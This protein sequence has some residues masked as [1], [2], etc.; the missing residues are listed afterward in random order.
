MLVRSPNGTLL[1]LLALYSIPQT[2][3]VSTSYPKRMYSPPEE[4]VTSQPGP[5]R[6]DWKHILNDVAQDDAAQ[7]DDH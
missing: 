2:V 3:C 7:T 1:F 5:N 4:D 6:G